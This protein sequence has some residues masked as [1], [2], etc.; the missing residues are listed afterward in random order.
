[1]Q[2][3]K[4]ENARYAVVKYATSTRGVGLLDRAMLVPNVYLPQTPY[5]GMFEGR[6]ANPLDTGY[7]VAM[8]LR[9]YIC[10]SFWLTAGWS[11]AVFGQ[12]PGIPPL[13]RA[14]QLEPFFDDNHCGMGR[15]YPAIDFRNVSAT[16]CTLPADTSVMA[17]RSEERRAGK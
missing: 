9:L 14:V 17:L 11:A 10:L 5:C 6:K 2:A 12:L 3:R 16:A 4:C 7:R 15:C 13:C 1:M 8:V